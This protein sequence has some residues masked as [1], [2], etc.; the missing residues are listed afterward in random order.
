M[1]RIDC[2]VHVGT[3]NAKN[4]ENEEDIYVKY[5]SSDELELEGS[6]TF[7]YDYPLSRPAK[8]EHIIT[9]NTTARDILTIAKK[10]YEEIY[11]L[12]EEADGDP[13]NI[14]GMLNRETSDGPYG[15]WG[16][17]ISDLY[18]EGIRIDE[19]N[20]QVKFSIGS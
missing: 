3:Y 7:V 20:R 18:F 19:K 5:P 2:N 15:I 11:R 10:D 13:G 6:F 9:T 12:E 14:E 1:K 8:F 16:H 4:A 17:G